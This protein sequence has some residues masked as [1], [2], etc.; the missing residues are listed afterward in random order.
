MRIWK[1]FLPSLRVSQGKV[2]P[3]ASQLA[4]H[5]L[6]SR[7]PLHGC[8]T[9]PLRQLS[10]V[11]S[12]GNVGQEAALNRMVVLWGGLT[13]V[14]YPNGIVIFCSKDLLEVFHPTQTLHHQIYVAGR[15]FD[16]SVIV[17][18]LQARR[19][20]YGLVVID[21]EEATLGI[22]HAGLPSSLIGCR[23]SKLEHISSN[24]ASRT[25]RGGQSALRYSRLRDGSELAF[26]RKVAEKSAEHFSD[27]CSLVIGGKADMKRKLLL[28]LPLTLR[29]RIAGVVDLACGAGLEGLQRLALRIDEFCHNDE[30]HHQEHTVHRFL[31]LVDQ[32]GRQ[33]AQIVCYG[34]EQ[35]IAALRMGAV[36][37]LLVAS[38]QFPRNSSRRLTFEELAKTTGAVVTEV[39]S[40][41]S[42]AVHFSQGFQV[43]CFL[44][45]PVDPVLLD[46]APSEGMCDLIDSHHTCDQAESDA[47]TIST[48]ASKTDNVLLQ[49]LEGALKHA[50]K[51]A[52]TANALTVCA[53]VILSDESTDAGER[54][55]NT[56]DML[57]EEAV[58]E[59]V[60]VELSVH[61]SDLLEVEQF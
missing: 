51:D 30:L 59:S 35:T 23:V 18:S 47:E 11:P 45:W 24:I 39:Q 2:T 12:T 33:N 60:L 25:R 20:L 34:E 40:Q 42:K 43:G 16:T 48:T 19:A 50:L 53:E 15:H 52:S 38:S 32:S 28:E 61:I 22:A 41:G 7:R 6:I 4:L 26:L 57:R 1:T 8:K 17:E 29:S 21:G 46:D 36:Q 10:R 9:L 13:S 55:Q 44:R 3:H 14:E 31:E 37:H 27:L 56:I 5:L 54:L 58:P 49:W